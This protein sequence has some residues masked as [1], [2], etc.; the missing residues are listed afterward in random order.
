MSSV[1]IYGQ[2]GREVRASEIVKQIEA[3][4]NDSLSVY[5]NSPGGNVYEGMAIFN[6]LERHSNVSTFIDG[7]AYSAASW[8]ALAAPREKRFMA[9]NAQFGI[10]QSINF[11]GGNKDDLQAQIEILERVDK[12]QTELYQ[13]KTGLQESEIQTLMKRDSPLSFE[14]AL[15]FGFVS[16]EHQ[17]AEIA[18][19]FNINDNM[20]L[21]E[22][23]SSVFNKESKTPDL[24]KE[25]AEKEA[26]AAFEKA[27]DVEAQFTAQFAKVSDL[28][29]LKGTLEPF[30]ESIL[31]KWNALPTK[32][33]IDNMVAAKTKLAVAEW[34]SKIRTEGTVFTQEETQFAEAKKEESYEA[35][36]LGKP[37]FNSL[38]TKETK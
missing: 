24:I 30:I 32:E 2:I 13:E 35:L 20:D 7:L 26:K 37:D 25:E 18:A 34:A 36:T 11:A 8:I 23:M 33:D 29:A 6:A 10:H 21:F 4:K 19:L 15:S 5:I 28:E 17:P 3:A 9:K 16:G 1:F 27:E 31:D 38:F 12:A 22:K 14:E